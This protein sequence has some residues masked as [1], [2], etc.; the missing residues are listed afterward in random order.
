VNLLAR[1]GVDCTVKCVV[2]AE[3]YN[4]A[5]STKHCSSL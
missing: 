2:S 5:K 3:S 4:K 1:V